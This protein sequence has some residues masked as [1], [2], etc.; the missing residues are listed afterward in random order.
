MVMSKRKQS[1]L[2][3]ALSSGRM[4]RA[5]IVCTK[6]HYEL[7]VALLRGDI[8]LNQF[9]R[10]LEVPH[11]LGYARVISI[12]RDGISKGAIRLEVVK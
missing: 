10:A 2:N 8:S 7:V 4:R 9:Q 6:E 5:S 12:A 3:K 11:P 1:L